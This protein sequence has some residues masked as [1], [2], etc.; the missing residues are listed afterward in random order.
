MQQH[1]FEFTKLIQCWQSMPREPGQAPQ[2]TTFSPVSVSSLM[3]YLF[4]IERKKKGGLVVRLLGSELEELMGC[5]DGGR[6]VFDVLM[7]RDWGFYERFMQGCGDHLCAGR[8]Q[9]SVQLEDGLRRNV[10]S[11]HVPLAGKS[12]EARFMLGVVVNRANRD[13]RA[14]AQ[15]ETGKNAALSYQYVDLGCGMPREA[16]SANPAKQIVKHHQGTGYKSPK[17][18]RPANTEIYAPV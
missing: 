3:P 5:S 14:K 2:K 9:R 15:L 1:P 11:L 16:A 13:D 8:L 6:R 18:R 17:K 10:D 7:H 12:G 4:L